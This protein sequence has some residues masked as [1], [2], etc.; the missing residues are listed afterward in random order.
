[1][2]NKNSVKNEGKKIERYQLRERGHRRIRE[3][4]VVLTDWSRAVANAPNLKL[5]RGGRK[6]E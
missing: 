6:N 4:D 5:K 3:R 1:V 2:R